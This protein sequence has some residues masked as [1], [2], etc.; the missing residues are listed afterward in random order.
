M[1]NEGDSYIMGYSLYEKTSSLSLD[2]NFQDVPD[3]NWCDINR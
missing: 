1:F 3:D 2:S